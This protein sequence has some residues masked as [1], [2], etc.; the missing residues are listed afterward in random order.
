MSS[1][2]RHGPCW[3]MTSVL[4]RPISLSASALSQSPTLPTLGA[5]PASARRS[6]NRI[7]VY[8]EPATSRQYR[9][10]SSQRCPPAEAVTD[11]RS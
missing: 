6:V 5:A 11:S 2:L 1:R 3:R 8:W 10:P 4:N 9:P 7:D